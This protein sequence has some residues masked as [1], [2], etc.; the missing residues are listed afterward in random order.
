MNKN[1]KEFITGLIKGVQ[2]GLEKK[3]T[4]VKGD[5][6]K[7][8]TD[9]K[10]S[11]EKQIRHNGVLIEH[12]KSNIE[13]LVESNKTLHERVGRVETNVVDIKETISDYHIVRET[14]KKHGRQL[15]TL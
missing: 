8:I 9:V 3:I 11:L 14:V 2:S 10:K 15:A 4:D 1:D 5:L 7:Q 13:W 12:N 6:V